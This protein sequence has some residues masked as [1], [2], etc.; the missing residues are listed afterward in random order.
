[1]LVIREN[2]IENF[3]K[4]DA[5]LNT[6]QRN[7]SLTQNNI[8]TLNEQLS[9]RK[10]DKQEI[11]LE[12]LRDKERADIYTQMLEKCESDIDTLSKRIAE[13]DDIDNTI[14]N[15]KAII[16]SSIDIFNKIIDEGTISDSDLRMLIDKI[17]ISEK[18]GKLDINIILNGKFKEHTLDFNE[19]EILNLVS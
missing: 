6:W 10:S 11:L 18:D 12:R 14:K 8:A 3:R 9:Q 4:I 2:A 17:I 15:R 16:S 5:E 7:K 19:V 13:L 1:M